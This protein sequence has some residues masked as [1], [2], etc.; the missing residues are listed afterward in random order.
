MKHLPKFF[1]F[2]C[3]KGKKTFSYCALPENCYTCLWIDFK[4]VL[5]VFPTRRK[6]RMAQVLK[7]SYHSLNLVVSN[8]G[9]YL[10]YPIKIEFVS[11]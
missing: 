9:K 1:K 5:S 10:G 7:T 3:W 11:N 4:I 2:D 6:L 8:H